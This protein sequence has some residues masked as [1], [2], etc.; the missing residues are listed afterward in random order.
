MSLITNEQNVGRENKATERHSQTLH[1]RNLK[2]GHRLRKGVQCGKEMIRTRKFV[3]Y[4]SYMRSSQW[5]RVRRER[6]RIDG[7]RCAICGARENL[8]VHHLSYERLGQPG[9][10]YDLV[11]LCR[12]CHMMLH[13]RHRKEHQGQHPH[14]R[15]RSSLHRVFI[16]NVLMN[17]RAYEGLLLSGSRQALVRPFSGT[18][19]KIQ[20]GIYMCL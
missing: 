2:A 9:E 8:Q 16:S 3:N 5:R 15:F 10:I 6:R 20:N 18:R 13:R 14:A 19:A 4:Y 17:E 11:T 7:F 12:D 1:G